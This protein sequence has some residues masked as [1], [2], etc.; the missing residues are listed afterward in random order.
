MEFI[1]NEEE[2]EDNNSKVYAR[3][4]KDKE[5]WKFQEIYAVIIGIEP[6]GIV[7]WIVRESAKVASC[8][9]SPSAAIFLTTKLE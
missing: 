3:I 6:V 9:L 4:E 8:G 7:M 2:G 5:H 1:W